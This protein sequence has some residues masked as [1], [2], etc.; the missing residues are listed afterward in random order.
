[1]G[2]AIS[3]LGLVPQM[4]TIHCYFASNTS[5]MPCLSFIPA[6]LFAFAGKW[7]TSNLFDIAY[8]AGF[9][10]VRRPTLG[11]LPGTR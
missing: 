10:L 2:A 1:M 5:G 7:M 9:V 8:G 6:Q 4:R 11:Q 3:G